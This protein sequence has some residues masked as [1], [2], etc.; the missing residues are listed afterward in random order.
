[1][2]QN[3]YSLA[4]VD[5]GGYCDDIVWSEQNEIEELIRIFS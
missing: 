4:L 3:M 1:M 2:L 5:C